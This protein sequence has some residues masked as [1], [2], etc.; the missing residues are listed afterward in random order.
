MLNEFWGLVV[1]FSLAFSDDCLMSDFSLK[2][3]YCS[4]LNSLADLLTGITRGGEFATSGSLTSILPGVKVDGV[5]RVAF[6]LLPEQAT[7]IASVADQAPYGRGE[8]TLVDRNIRD[9]LQIEPGRFQ[10]LGGS[11]EKT[12]R[13][14]VDRAT[15][16]LGCETAGVKAELY[17][18][19]I[20]PAGGFF[21]CHR[22][23]EKAAGMFASLVVCLPSEHD[24]GELIV[25][26]NQEEIRIDLS[27]H[28]ESEIL[29]AAFYCD[30]EHE[31]LPVDS[32]HRLCL[33]YN[34]IK[35]SSSHQAEGEELPRVPD[36]RRDVVE[37]TGILSEWKKFRGRASK[38]AYLLDHQYTPA[39]LSFTGLKL[40]DAA[41]VQVLAQAADQAGFEIRL[42]LVH[43]VEEGSADVYDYK[44]D[45]HRGRGW[46]DDSFPEPENYKLIE[47]YN[48]YQFIDSW[49]D[50]IGTTSDFGR[51]PLEKGELLPDGAL[52]GEAPDEIRVSEATGNEGGSYERAYHRA[53]AVVWVK[54]ETED[55][56]LQRGVEAAIPHF[57][58]LVAHSS[59]KK[60]RVAI[61]RLAEKMLTKWRLLTD[62]DPRLGGS[63][64]GR[65]ASLDM[66]TALNDFGET[67]LVIDFLRDVLVRCYSGVENAELV[68]ACA[69]CCGSAPL[70]SIF[71]SLLEEKLARH[72]SDLAQWFHLA[73]KR[74]LP[75]R[76]LHSV[77]QA[78]I[79]RLSLLPVIPPDP[80][81]IPKKRDSWTYDYD[82]DKTSKQRRTIRVKALSV[83]MGAIAELR[84]PGN[85]WKHLNATIQKLPDQIERD[86]VLFRVLKE[87][88]KDARCQGKLFI[89]WQITAEFLLKRSAVE[90][91]EPNDWTMRDQALVCH[92]QHCS[93]IMA[94]ALDPTETCL[95]IPINQQ[96][97]QHV[98]N[99][100]DR[101]GLEMTH[102]TERKGRPFTL[103]LKK[104]R[105]RYEARTR[106]YRADCKRMEELVHMSEV[107]GQGKQ[108]ASILTRLKE[109]L[110]GHGP[111]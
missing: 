51:I 68:R 79:D 31:V 55:L 80:G 44:Y 21:S 109:A 76:F 46:D 48:D 11:W 27:S 12:L 82:Y 13:Q 97:R 62:R 5:G 106:E 93:Q 90:P 104:T 53:V 89:L 111:E 47:A 78:M 4:E 19:L 73:C 83:F 34:L 100:I 25:R 2:I 96:A 49:I 60:D 95:R 81:P 22:D 66:L 1:V 67:S 103:V 61:K 28:Q 105:W 56:L 70:D 98:H 57:A 41:R 10:L 88:N 71:V 84:Q 54:G 29:F 50:P 64:D 91:A 9:V 17:K 15:Q 3:D 43:I 24:G 38:I 26:H 59:T 86:L 33:V 65:K 14:I 63:P 77:A 74:K 107:F 23:T 92:C 45:Y 102:K 18:L 108:G 94:F 99:E 69:H 42:G 58:N 72:F 37:A 75:D 8:D 85:L 110:S 36:D 101:A 16:G 87:L 40:Q 7:K 32:G 52:D 6:P 39:G 20:Y 35:V 30:C